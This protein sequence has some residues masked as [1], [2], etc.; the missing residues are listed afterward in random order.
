ML[1]LGATAIVTNG[2]FVPNWFFAP[3]AKRIYA[4]LPPKLANSWL[5][6]RYANPCH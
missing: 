5:T 4:I 2:K 6:E 3:L 1:H